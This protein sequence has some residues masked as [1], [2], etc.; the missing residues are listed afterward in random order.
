MADLCLLNDVKRYLGIQTANEDILLGYLI[1]GASAWVEN[2]TNRTFLTSSYSEES[3]GKDQTS[4]FFRQY[5]V[6]TVASMTVDGVAV[7]QS[8]SPT[9]NG[10]RLVNAYMARLIGYNLARDSVVQ[11]SYTAGYASLAALPQDIPMAVMEIVALRFREKEWIGKHSETLQTQVV[12]FTNSDVP[13]DVRKTLQQYNR[14]VP[15]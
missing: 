7:P 2:F 13:A 11:V 15:M 6:T 9:A 8:T 14:V 12:S 10:W 5:P 4:Y 1:T 3:I